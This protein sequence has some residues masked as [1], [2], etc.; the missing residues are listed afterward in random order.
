MTKQAELESKE[1][2]PKEIVA[3]NKPDTKGKK[4]DKVDEEALKLR[5]Q[6][7]K[8]AFRPNWL[9]EQINTQTK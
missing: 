4:P 8:K 9:I 6:R 2:Q 7:V 3:D 1:K 5:V